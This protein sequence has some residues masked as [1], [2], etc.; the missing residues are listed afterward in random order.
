MASSS[1]TYI[2]PWQMPRVTY[3]LPLLAAAIAAVFYSQFWLSHDNSWFLVATRKFLD[4]AR[5]YV[6]I[7][8]VNPPLNFYLTVPALLVAETI[9]ISDTFAYVIQ[10]CVLGGLSG[11]WL[12]RLLRCSDLAGREQWAILLPALTGLFVLPIGEFAQREHLLFI[13]ALPYLT[14][15]ILGPERVRLETGE[16]VLL[17]L[18]ATFGLALKPYFLLIPAAIALV[19]PIKLL[20]GRIFAPA[21]LGLAAGLVAYALFTVLAHPEFFS[22]VLDTARRVYWAYGFSAKTVLQRREVFAVLIFAYLF[23]RGGVSHDKVSQRFSA[24]VAAAL[25]SYLIQFKGWN[26]Q[27]IPM[28]YFLLAGGIW[29]ALEKKVFEARQYVPAVMLMAIVA[30]TLG[31]QLLAGPYTSRTLHKFAPY[32]EGPGETI[33]V[34]STNVS[35][36]FPFVN[37][38]EG[39]WASRY[40][41]Q[42]TIPGAV[43][44]LAS[45]RCPKD[46]EYC[47]PLQKILADIRVANTQDLLRNRPDVI[48]VDMRKK[49]SYFHGQAF[50]YLAFQLEDPEFAAVWTQYR[51]EAEVDEDFAV[52]RRAEGPAQ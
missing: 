45:E 15:L 16:K 12:V 50:D 20:A 11:L 38:V 36:A 48:F 30:A 23:A 39:K 29:I 9:G 1:P 35:A 5:L 18:V 26:Y 34:Y 42:W 13:Y 24:A 52:F 41:A 31:T 10:T 25:A 8:E 37:A 28:V 47:A 51:K 4:G 21:N 22:D 6:D 40:P 2:D 17:G 46:T 14:Y 49:K 33:M 43:I 3:A 32:V 19:G 27:L 7:V 44:G